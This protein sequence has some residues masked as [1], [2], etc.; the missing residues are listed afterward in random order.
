MARSTTAA[1][2]H[3]YPNPAKDFINISATSSTLLKTIQVYGGDGKF[4][5]SAIA[6]NLLYYKL[7]ISKLTRGNYILMIK[8]SNDMVIAK[9]FNF[10][11]NLIRSIL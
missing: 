9:Q 8:L 10:T 3:F 5:M 4:H 2:I 6:A 7:D 11:F 1:N